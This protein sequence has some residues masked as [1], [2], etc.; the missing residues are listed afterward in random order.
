MSEIKCYI[1]CEKVYHPCSMGMYTISDNK[2][3]FDF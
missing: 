1:F 2:I 3:D